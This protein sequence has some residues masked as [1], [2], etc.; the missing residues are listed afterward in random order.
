MSV[1]RDL[2]PA[3]LHCILPYCLGIA[4]AFGLAVAVAEIVAGSG[5]IDLVA[6]AVAVIAAV[7]IAAAERSACF[8][9]IGQEPFVVAVP[10]GERGSMR[11]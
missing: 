1:K 11:L 8:E 4:V 9:T 5:T 6:I 3:G 7:V 10:V 2:F